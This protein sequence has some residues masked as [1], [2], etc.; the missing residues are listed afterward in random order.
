VG[1]R[2]RAAL[3]LA[4]LAVTA[5]AVCF[6]GLE[7]GRGLL[8]VDETLRKERKVPRRSS[9]RGDGIFGLIGVSLWVVS[10]AGLLVG[11]LAIHD[12]L[13]RTSSAPHVSRKGAVASTLTGL[14]AGGVLGGFLGGA[15]PA[16]SAVVARASALVG[17]FVALFLADRLSSGSAE[18]LRLDL[19]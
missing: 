2:T 1:Q 15:S 16:I 9:S 14:V 11:P 7:V 8:T 17:S 4:F 18:A 3:L 10:A 6:F 13:G 5:Q 19:N 12:R